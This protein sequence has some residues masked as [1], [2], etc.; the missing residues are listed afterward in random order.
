M[1]TKVNQRIKP[2][3]FK[4]LPREKVAIIKLRNLGYPIHHL[5]RALGRSTSFIHK[6]L[7]EAK[8]FGLLKDWIY[9][10]RKC[11]RKARTWSTKRKLDSLLFHIKQWESFIL[12]E[13]GDPP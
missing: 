11:P 1:I 4:A 10:Q 8:L 3:H 2:F 13:E 7:R 5:A 9:D 12:G 6:T